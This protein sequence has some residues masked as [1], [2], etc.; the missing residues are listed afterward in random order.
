MDEC[1]TLQFKYNEF[2]NSTLSVNEPG[3]CYGN[4]HP[5]GF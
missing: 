1:L 3:Y 4:N 5:A 2:E